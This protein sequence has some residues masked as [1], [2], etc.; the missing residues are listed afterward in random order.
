MANGLSA[1]TV[2]IKKYAWIIVLGGVMLAIL[3]RLAMVLWQAP[4]SIA[5]PLPWNSG[6][7]FKYC[8]ELTV[9][10][11]ATAVRETVAAWVAA[12]AAALVVLIGN[13]LGPDKD[14][15]SVWLK[16]RGMLCS[17][18]G[19]I[20]GVIATYSFARADAASVAA[21]AATEAIAEIK[22]GDKETSDWNAYAACVRVRAAWLRSRVDSAAFIR[23]ALLKEPGP[24]PAATPASSAPAN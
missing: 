18:A 2:F 3:V 9:S 1:V 10:E 4:P 14:A 19:V 17:G 5:A 16:N 6:G 21:S 23:G 20:I 15:D 22:P 11:Q 7:G 13:V 24:G 12:V 8:T